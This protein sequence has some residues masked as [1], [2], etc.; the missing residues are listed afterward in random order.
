MS[1]LRWSLA[2]GANMGWLGLVPMFVNDHDP[3]PL[4]EQIN[5]RYA[6]GGGWMPLSGWS[7]D[8]QTHAIAYPDDLES[9]F[10]FAEYVHP[11][12][13]ER[14]YAYKSSWFAIVQPDDK[15]E[16]ARLD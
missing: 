1:R 5:E 2:A 13:G 12:T 7:Y 3:R 15:Y 16:V 4:A 6:H 8:P 9:L 14:L 10:P 11:V